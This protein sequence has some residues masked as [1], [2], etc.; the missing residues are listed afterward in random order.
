MDEEKIQ[1]SPEPIQTLPAPHS[2]EEN[3][4]SSSSSSEVSFPQDISKSS[5]DGSDINLQE[6]TSRTQVS[7]AKCPD[8]NVPSVQAGS[9]EDHVGIM[10]GNIETWSPTDPERT[11]AGHRTD[12]RR[13]LMRDGSFLVPQLKIS[14]TFQEE[15]QR[16]ARRDPLHKMTVQVGLFADLLVL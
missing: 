11:S 16:I 7:E 12:K 2:R 13:T 5:S 10:R 4:R 3:Y 15:L 8:P 9:F 1:V 6:R 14:K